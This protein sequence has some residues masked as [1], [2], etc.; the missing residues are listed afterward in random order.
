M[1]S[2]NESIVSFQESE[3]VGKWFF[4]LKEESTRRLE[5]NGVKTT[6]DN[7]CTY[8]DEESFYSHRKDGTSGRM[9]TLIWKNDEE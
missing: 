2:D 6:S 7:W 5:L 4:N 3:K 9:V 1:N 8:R